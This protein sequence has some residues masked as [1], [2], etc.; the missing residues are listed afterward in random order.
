VIDGNQRHRWEKP[1]HPGYEAAVVKDEYIGFGAPRGSRN[2]QGVD[3]SVYGPSAVQINDTVCFKRPLLET[4]EKTEAFGYDRDR[5]YT[6]IPKHIEAG[7]KGLSDAS[8]RL[9]RTNHS[10]SHGQKKPLS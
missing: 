9:D 1:L 5:G 3:C 10:A 7:Q 8:A 6:L 2:C 4:A